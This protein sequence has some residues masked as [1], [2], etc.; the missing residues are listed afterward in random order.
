MT[1]ISKLNDASEELFV[2]D[3]IKGYIKKEN[4]TNHIGHQ[5]TS[6]LLN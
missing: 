6:L 1:K 2:R 3:I 5:K 4:D